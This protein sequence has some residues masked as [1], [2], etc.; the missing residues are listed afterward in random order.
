[1]V[2]NCPRRLRGQLVQG[3]PPP[4]NPQALCTVYN[5]VLKIPQ[6]HCNARLHDLNSTMISL[7]GRIIS[8]TGSASGMGLATAKA[9]FARGAS[10]SLADYREDA[11][12]QARNEIESSY[13]SNSSEKPTILAT[14]VDIRDSSQVDSWIE[15][16][17]S[18]FGR[19]DGAANIAGVLGQNFGVHDP[20][21]LSNE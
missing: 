12:K 20:T 14:A 1:M 10:L 13:T 16:T 15:K 4:Q 5:S 6:T 8:I 19:L 18:H 3:T 17:V 21:Q 2:R 7:A 11:L 9:L